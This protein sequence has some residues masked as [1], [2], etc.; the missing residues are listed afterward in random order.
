VRP[1]DDRI[2][3][4]DPPALL[5]SRCIECGA[6]FFP[7]RGI[8]GACFCDALEDT[9]SAGTGLI[10]TFTIVRSK[11]PGYEGPVPYALGIVELD[12]GLRVE[13]NLDARDLDQLAI[14][15][16]VMPFAKALFEA[17]REEMAVVAYCPEEPDA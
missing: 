2:Y 14:G 5:T 6:R 17:G 9:V 10:Y 7:R 8:C 11:G 1:L 3:S 12:E 13:V 4:L 16:R 15:D